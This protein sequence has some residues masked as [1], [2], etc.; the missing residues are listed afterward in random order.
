MST[1]KDD[2]QT[3]THHKEMADV[4]NA[5]RQRIGHEMDVYESRPVDVWTVMACVVRCAGKESNL[6]L[7]QS[8]W[9]IYLS[10]CP[11]PGSRVHL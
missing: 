2:M 6:S 4:D 7:A 9:T 11:T 1:S 3:D 10:V 8:L 5:I